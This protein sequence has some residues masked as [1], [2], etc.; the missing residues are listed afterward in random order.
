MRISDSE[1]NRLQVLKAIR[2]AE[3]VAR[4]DLVKLTGLATGTISQLTADFVRRGLAL[5]EKASG[6]AMGRPRIELRINA[7][8]GYV[9]SLF[10][11]TFG[12][13]TLEIVDLRGDPVFSYSVE[14][15]RDATL[16]DRARRLARVIDEAI[17]AS[18]LSKDQIYRVGVVVHGLVDSQ[19]GEVHWLATYPEGPVPFARLIEDELGIQVA[20][21]NDT[22]IIARAE[23][24]FGAE[25]QVDDFAALVVTT[26][27]S[28]AY[29]AG[30]VLWAGASGLN[31]EIGHTKIGGPDPRPCYCGMTGCLATYCATF[32]I[33][34]RI[35][36][37]RGEAAPD[38]ADE[39]A[40]LRRF[41][42]DARAGEPVA[43]GAF[44]LAGRMLGLAVA[45]M[46]VDRDPGRVM[47]MA[48]EPDL[49]ALIRPAFDAALEANT[50]P[51]AFKR[52]DVRFAL[53]DPDHYRKGAAALALE[54]IYRG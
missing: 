9:L 13:A 40:L 38:L 50:L 4:T 30:G 52:A 7:E 12:L 10:H 6:R 49:L 45:N 27:L 28:S 1:L 19:K 2:R 44:D 36:E 53:I 18:P 26:A 54:Q 29:Y 32:G 37:Q 20:I 43:S 46:L 24:W 21:D 25:G 35:C 5:E 42:E 3:P 15:D 39:G 34:G 48:F 16:P 14:L 31:A 11:R 23:H 8:A 33:V 51:T 41:A 17:A 47:I 22:N